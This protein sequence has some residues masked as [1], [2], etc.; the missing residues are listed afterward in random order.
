LGAR[1]SSA[2]QLLAAARQRRQVDAT[3]H[4]AVMSG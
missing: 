2:A 4:R 1:W 3:L